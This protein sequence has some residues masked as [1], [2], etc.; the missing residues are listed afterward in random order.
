MPDRY[1]LWCI[2]TGEED[3]VDRYMGPYD[4]EAAARSVD[5]EATIRRCRRLAPSEVM[6]LHSSM[7]AEEADDDHEAIAA[8]APVGAWAPWERKSIVRV[9]DEAAATTALED[10]ADAHLEVDVFVCEGDEP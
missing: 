1:P 8:M 10:W 7:I 5:P 2:D 4:T 6:S 9:R 3:D